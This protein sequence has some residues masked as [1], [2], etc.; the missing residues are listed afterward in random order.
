MGFITFLLSQ[1]VVTS[2]AL[3]ALKRNGIITVDASK[4]KNDAAKVAFVT[5]LQAGDGVCE[6]GERAWS[7]MSKNMK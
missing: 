4:I 2:V 3:A 6:W 1:T 5:A 7:E